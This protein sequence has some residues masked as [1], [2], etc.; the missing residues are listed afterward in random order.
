MLAN[1]MDFSYLPELQNLAKKHSASSSTDRPV[2]MSMYPIYD[3]LYPM[4]ASS[5]GTGNTLNLA[6]M[7]HPDSAEEFDVVIDP[8]ISKHHSI[9]CYPNEVTRIRYNPNGYRVSVDGNVG[10][11][12]FSVE[13]EGGVELMTIGAPSKALRYVTVMFTPNQP[14]FKEHLVM[15]RTKE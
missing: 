6:G 4:M 3:D 11:G 10:E 14:G 7:M 8:S 2:A 15:I 9:K 5:T 13:K 12:T 1:N